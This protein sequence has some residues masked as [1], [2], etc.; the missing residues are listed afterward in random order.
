MIFIDCVV[1]LTY[2]VEGW[3]FSHN[4]G[5]FVSCKSIARLYSE[6]AVSS[7]YRFHLCITLHYYSHA[8]QIY[9]S[10]FLRMI[11]STQD[12]VGDFTNQ[13]LT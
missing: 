11:D 12:R 4:V 8:K 5:V 7:I 10:T 1:I 3:S 9:I 2:I 6:A 13:Q